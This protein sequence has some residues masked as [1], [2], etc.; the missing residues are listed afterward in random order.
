MIFE[1]QVLEHNDT[2]F[3]T[4]NRHYKHNTTNIKTTKKNK[5]TVYMHERNI[6]TSN[7]L[8]NTPILRIVFFLQR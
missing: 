5:K 1:S 2:M 3:H 4:N 8:L 6:H 7:M